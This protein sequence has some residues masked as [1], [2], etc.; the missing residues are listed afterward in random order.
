MAQSRGVAGDEVPDTDRVLTL[1]NAL[2]VLR[3]LGVP[4]F[5]WLILRGDD[6]YERG[7]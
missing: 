4:L 1:P 3:L 2:S 7:Q 6:G 5:L